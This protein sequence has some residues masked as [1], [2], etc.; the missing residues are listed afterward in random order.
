MRRSGR[1][2]RVHPVNELFNPTLGLLLQAAFSFIRVYSLG[3]FQ[4]KHRGPAAAQHRLMVR[5]YGP[6]LSRAG[7]P[8]SPKT[9]ASGGGS[10]NHDQHRWAGMGRE[11]VGFRQR[12]G[13]FEGV[14]PDLCHLPAGVGVPMCRC[15]DVPMCRCADVGGGVGDLCCE[16]S[17]P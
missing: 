7:N 14:M 15:A 5:E 8:L 13:G 4:V 1:R 9:G 11:P 17:K 3:V 10:G 2:R 6:M 16:S 12:R